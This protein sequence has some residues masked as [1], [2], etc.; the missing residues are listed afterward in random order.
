MSLEVM[1]EDSSRTDS[2]G[3]GGLRSDVAGSRVLSDPYLVPPGVQSRGMALN[4]S[5]APP[6]R[7]APSEGNPDGPESQDGPLRSPVRCVSPEFV[8]AIALNPG[9]R[10]KEVN[11]CSAWA[12]CEGRAQPKV[13]YT[14]HFQKTA[15]S[16]TPTYYYSGKY[17]ELPHP[18]TLLNCSD[19]CSYEEC[20]CVCVCV[21][22]CLPETH[23]QLQRSLRGAGGGSSQPHALRWW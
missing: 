3:S 17:L 4:E 2:T 6:R 8:N 19:C 21:C 9:G 10:P 1:N 12:P 5:F 11:C 13:H 15:Q 14:W 16:V 7:R 18:P 23:A 22:F 20:L